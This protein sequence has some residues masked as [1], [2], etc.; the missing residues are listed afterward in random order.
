MS[1]SNDD[2]EWLK[3]LER[4]EAEGERVD[5]KPGVRK[6]VK[7]SLSQRRAVRIPHRQEKRT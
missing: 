2:N 4:R 1:R 6:D 3:E 5:K 7:V